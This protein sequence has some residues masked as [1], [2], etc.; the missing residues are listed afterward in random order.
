M[1][2]LIYTINIQGFVAVIEK[3]PYATDIGVLSPNN[4]LV[5]CMRSDFLIY[6]PRPNQDLEDFPTINVRASIESHITAKLLD[7]SVLSLLPVRN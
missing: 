4:P 5:I 2:K 7:Q 1:E 6:N 3:A